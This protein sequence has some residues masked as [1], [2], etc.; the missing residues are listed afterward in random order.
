M[1]FNLGA[2][3]G[4][5]AQSG[6]NTYQM[7]EGIESQKKRDALIDLQAQ[8]MKAAMEERAALKEASSN[9][10]GQVGAPETALPG[11]KLSEADVANAYAID[12]GAPEAVAPKMY[13]QA[14]AD[15]DY[16]AKV[17]SI[18][19]ERALD[20][21]GK[22]TQTAI[23]KSSLARI[24]AE[25]EFS[26]WMQ[27]S[28]AQ[29]AKDPVGF[30]KEN[31][32]AYNNAK[33]GSHLDDGNTASIAASADG[34]SFSFVR[35]DAKGKL[36]DSTPIDANTAALA[37][38]HIAFDKYSSLPGK[39]K[40]AEEL[41]MRK[42]ELGYKGEE[43]GIKKGEL[44]VHQDFYGKGGTYE[45]V[46]GLKAGA[47]GDKSI[48]A[49][50]GEYAEALVDAGAINPSTKKPYTAQE[51]K[52]YA[53]G[54]VL[55]DPNAKGKA[56]WKSVAGNPDIQENS[57]GVQREWDPKTERYKV[58]GLPQVNENAA[59]L[60]VRGVFDSRLGEVGFMGGDGNVY[61]TEKEAIEA[62][63]KK[64]EKPAAAIPRERVAASPAAIE[65]SKKFG[66]T[67]ITTT[68]APTTPQEIEA[69]RR[70]YT[71]Y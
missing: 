50:A 63:T 24:K 28:Q 29:A 21:E 58:R 8:E 70:R 26:T 2:F 67:A 51:A 68:R 44:K 20:I 11:R 65:A 49:K 15:A 53:L 16:L 42:T 55:H 57:Q 4:A 41:G 25:D 61:T 31:L 35:T 38:K 52:Q 62:S 34:K 18:S 69:A 43:V 19:P 5:A 3:A 37:L 7:L 17:R 1:A 6:M 66:G 39:Y 30:L 59:K 45:R 46:A 9:T 47:G 22:Q 64:E 54:V 23:G 56:E 36:V 12:Q 13:T 71:G 14:Q 48:K 33:K 40:E 27:N 32:G 60:G 10:Y